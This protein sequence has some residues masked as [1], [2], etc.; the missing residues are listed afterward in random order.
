MK[1]ASKRMQRACGCCW[2]PG[3]DGAVVGFAR[4]DAN[5]VLDRGDKDL[6]VA[7]LAGAGG[8][9]DGLNGLVDGAF[10]YHHLDLDLGQKTHRVFGAAV[11]FRM[12]LLPSITLEFGYGHALEPVI[13]SLLAHFLE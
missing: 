13:G 1:S 4:A 11:D 6:A 3:S 5:R 9:H 8:A 12:P 7:D 2:A 10:R